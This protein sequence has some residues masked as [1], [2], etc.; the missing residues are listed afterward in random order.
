MRQAEVLV[1]KIVAGTLT[2]TD[3]GRYV[4]KYNDAYLASAEL[5]A[6]SLAFP[7]FLSYLQS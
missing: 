1:N 5:P 6:I 4:F 3:D 7:V 2:E